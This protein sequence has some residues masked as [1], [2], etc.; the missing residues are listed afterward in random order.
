MCACSDLT[1][2]LANAHLLTV[3]DIA[4]V[5]T[6]AQGAVQDA[7]GAAPA[8]AGAGPFD[9]LARLMEGALT[10]RAPCHNV[11]TLPKVGYGGNLLL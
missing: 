9:S 1:N 8:A 2:H 11:K 6:A 3:A 7:A 10:V 5:S 4:T